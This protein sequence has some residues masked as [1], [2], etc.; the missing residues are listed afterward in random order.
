MNIIVTYKY[1][2]D[3]RKASFKA[4]FIHQYKNYYHISD[5]PQIKIFS[6]QKIQNGYEGFWITVNEILKLKEE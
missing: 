1:T 4:S 6:A 2:K 5:I 3:Y